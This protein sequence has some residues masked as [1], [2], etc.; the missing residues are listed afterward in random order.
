MMNKNISLNIRFIIVSFFAVMV[1]VFQSCSKKETYDVTGDT[2]TRIFIN[3]EGRS[4]LANLKNSFTYT[5][6]HTVE[7]STSNADIQAKFAVQ[8]T[9]P[10]SSTVTVNAEVDNSLVAA[11]NTANN[12]SFAT[13]PSGAVTL[14]KTSVTIEQGSSISSDQIL[15]SVDQS[16]FAELTAPAYLLPIKLSSISNNAAKISTNYQTAYIVIN[17]KEVIVKPSVPASGML[18]ALVTNYS[19]WGITANGTPTTGT[20]LAQMFDGNVSTRWGFATHPLTITADM[21][22]T[23]TIGGFRLFAYRALTNGISFSNVVVS[24]S[25]DGVN[26][27]ELG[28]ATNA[29]MTNAAGYQYIGLYKTVQARYFRLAV[30]WSSTSQRGISELGVYVQ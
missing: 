22:E 18:G 5:I 23:K 2:E 16:K 4:S 8:S 27:K 17:T 29:T 14:N 15:V 26:Y 6:Q 19:T 30:T 10:V 24:V 13:L 12:V 28:T 1:S 7:S 20:T 21:M 9:K 25:D 11:Y 3:S